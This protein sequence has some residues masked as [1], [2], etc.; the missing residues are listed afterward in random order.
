MASGALSLIAATVPAAGSAVGAFTAFRVSATPGATTSAS[1]L[2]GVVATVVLDP[3]VADAADLV[4]AVQLADEQ[5]AR[6]STKRE[7]AELRDAELAEAEL[8]AVAEQ[9]ANLD[10][11]EEDG[12]PEDL[13]ADCG[14]STSGLGAVRPWVRDA[15]ESLSCRFSEPTMFGVAGRGG[16]SD[17]PDGLALD[18]IV[19]RATGDDLAACALENMEAL[20]VKYVIWRQRINTGSGWESMEDRGGATANHMDHVHI[21]FERQAGS[22]A[23]PAC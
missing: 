17:H 13:D 1:A 14:V 10:L 9:R 19:D 18:F 22:G 12:V 7:E 3:E 16:P 2:S 15:A 20:G 5:I 8:A 6:A 21:S 4:K 11:P 23:A